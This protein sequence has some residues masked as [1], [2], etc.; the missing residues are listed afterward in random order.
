MGTADDAGVYALGDG[1]ALVQTI[2]IFAPVVDSA[3]DW[4][5][6]AAAN[7]LSDVYAMGATPLTALQYLGWPRDDLDF[8]LAAEVVRGGLDVMAEAA[9]TVVGGHS[10]D[11]PEPHYG[12]AVTGLADADRVLTN[13]GARAGDALVLTKPLG[14]GIITTAIKRGICPPELASEAITVMT[15]LNHRGSMAALSHGAN[16]VTDVT[17]FGLLG[18][19]QEMTAFASIGATINYGSVPVLEG[20]AE[21]LEEGAWAGGSNRNRVHI[22]DY[23]HTSLD[24]SPIRILCDAQTSGG[25]LIA[26][27][28]SKVASLLEHLQDGAHIGEIDAGPGITILP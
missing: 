6:I 14:I 27:E 7:A 2:D 20:V 10:I 17:G 4:G 8:D 23:I 28:A 11:G 19:L 22:D 15:T 9:C 25:L 12:F 13:Q 3:Y 21:L 26:I 18:H 1:R 5:R 16:A 24:E